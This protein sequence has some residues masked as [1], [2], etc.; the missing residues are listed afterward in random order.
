MS[1]WCRVFGSTNAEPAPADLLAELRRLGVT[2]PAH[3]T[4]DE[5]GW[6]RMVLTDESGET[7]LEIERYLASEEGIRAELNTWA[8]WLENAAPERPALLESVISAR[9]VF[10]LQRLSDPDADDHPTTWEHLC[11]FLAGRTGGYYQI[12]GQG[13]FAADGELLVPE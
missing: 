13:F 8:A 9:Q 12:D 11:R 6:F 1:I 2:G 3:F 4:G 7:L 10:T 5:Q